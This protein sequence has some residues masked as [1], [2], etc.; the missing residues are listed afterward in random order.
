MMGHRGC[1]LAA[2]PEACQN[3]TSAIIKAALNVVDGTMV[4]PEIMVPLAEK[5]LKYIKDIICETA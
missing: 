2:Y 4:R 1:R 3:A 5:R